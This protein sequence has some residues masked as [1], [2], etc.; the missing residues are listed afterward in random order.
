MSILSMVGIILERVTR[1][2]TMVSSTHFG[3]KSRM[4][5]WVP[6]TQVTAQVA[7][8]SARWKRAGHMDPD[9]RVLQMQ[10]GDGTQGMEIAVLVRQ[11]DPFGTAGGA[12]GIINLG[13]WPHRPG[14]SRVGAGR[15]RSG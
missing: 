5:T 11:H 8:A 13:A 6:P 12:A 2:L 14:P 10:L 1:S 15:G 3:S 7:Q 4:S 9:I